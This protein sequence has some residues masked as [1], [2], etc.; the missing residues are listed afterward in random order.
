VFT[1]IAPDVYVAEHRLVDGKNAI[2]FGRRGALAVDACN[3]ADEGEAMASFIRGAGC[4]PDRLALTHA[5]GDHI[6]GSGAFRGADVYAHIAAPL[7][8]ERHLPMWADRYFAGSIAAAEAAI[9]RP[10]VLFNSELRIDLDGKTIRLFGT[11][12]HCPDAACA[13]FEEDRV[14]CGGDTVVTGILPA[15]SDGDSRLLE[16]TLRQLTLLEVDVLIPGHGPVLHGRSTICEQLEW[17]VAYLGEVREV[18]EQ[19]LD[20]GPEAVLEAAEYARFVGDRLPQEPHGMLRRHRLVVTKI[21]EEATE[22]RRRE[23]HNGA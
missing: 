15:I 21:I 13:L 9:V 11:P 22:A 12:G 10:N 16:S 18:V 3:Y 8:I 2:V 14:L 19:C 23:G 7:T 4:T 17:M 20:D 6:L 1:E 5:H